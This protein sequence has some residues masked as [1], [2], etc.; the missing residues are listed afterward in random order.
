MAFGKPDLLGQLTE[1]QAFFDAQLLNAIGAHTHVI[2]LLG[3]GH[4]QTFV[5]SC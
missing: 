4:K 5:E 3:Q 2:C 1:R